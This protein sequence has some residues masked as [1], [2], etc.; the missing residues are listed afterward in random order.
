MPGTR[1]QERA[2]LTANEYTQGNI[3]GLSDHGTRRLIASTVLTESN[4][5]DLAITNTVGYVG[6]YQA[7]ATWLAD[8]GYVDTAKLQAAMSG[9][10]REWRWAESGGMTR[11]LEDPSNWKDG[12]SLEKYKASAD[13]QDQAFKRNSDSAYRTAIRQGV[14]H[15]GDSEEH[16]A[17]F[18]KARHIAGYGGAVNVVQ[19][20]AAAKDDYGTSSYDY[21]ND[22]A[23]NRD[24]LNQLLVPQDQFKGIPYKL[25]V[26]KELKP[27]D[28]NLSVKALQENLQLV[29]ATDSSGR[30]LRA[31]GDYGNNTREA[32]AEFQRQSNLPETGRADVGTLS[33]LQIRAAAIVA[34]PDF[35]Q[36]A[37]RFQPPGYRDDW[38]QTN[39]Q[40]LPN[41]LHSRTPT[42]SAP[43]RDAMADGVLKIGERGPEVARLQENLIQLGINDRLKDPIKADGVFG[44]DTQRAVQAFQL[45]HGT[46]HVSGIADKQTLA[47]ISTQTGL[48]I[49]QRAV[50]KATDHPTRDFATNTN[51]GV[52][53]DPASAADS[54]RV[55]EHASL[56]ATAATEGPKPATAASPAPAS[57]A[58][59]EP[60]KLSR[61]DQ[62]MFDKIRAGAPAHV[63]DEKIAEATLAAKRN[64]IAD[65][66]KI[67]AIGLVQDKLWIGGSTPGYH[68]SV[69]VSEP[70]PPMQDTLRET[71]AFNQ[72]QTQKP[73]QDADQRAHE[74]PS[75]GGR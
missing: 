35:H 28:A 43:V 56:P 53:P 13:L 57:G 20:R 17:G 15:A 50:D 30:P 19:N 21:Y 6:R 39:A 61:D 27:G 22:I 23:I 5:G 46:E 31:D 48:A 2:V 44:P 47:A 54:R 11:F 74:D 16:V 10:R 38:M 66:G 37:Q 68:A 71:Q 9:Y 58:P 34:A 59:Q 72:Q 36:A 25:P 26:E 41:Y 40:G 62:A 14:L 63:T 33:A 64:G 75:R 4:G 3:E 70:A 65:V 60:P 42:A 52:R 69:V 18:L 8:A 67:G 45:W 1:R 12:L 51:L 73:S 7:G 55:A 29:G 32:V 24:G 49:V